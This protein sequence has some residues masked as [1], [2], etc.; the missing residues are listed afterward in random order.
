MYLLNLTTLLL[1]AIVDARARPL[2]HALHGAS[3][4]PRK[5]AHTKKSMSGPGRIAS[6]IIA[7]STNATGTN[8]NPMLHTFDKRAFDGK[9]TFYTVSII[10]SRQRMIRSES[11]NTLCP[12]IGQGACGG[13]IDHEPSYVVALN[14]AQ[15]GGGYP[16][17]NCG[18]TITVQGGPLNGYAQGVITDL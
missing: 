8:Y 15:Y 17:P 7:H 11:L 10:Q 12:Q 9:A 16:G 1:V 5:D 14:Q 13:P 6:S 3:R 18:R 2:G 4:D